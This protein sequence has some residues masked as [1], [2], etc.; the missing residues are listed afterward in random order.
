MPVEFVIS[1][2]IAAF[3]A[4]AAVYMVALGLRER[5][6]RLAA[7]GGGFFLVLLA[8]WIAVVLLLPEWRPVLIIVLLSGAGFLLVLFFAPILNR[9]SEVPSPTERVDERGVMFARSRYRP[10]DGR[11]EVF[12]GER[13]ELK[14]TDDAIRGMSNIGEP[15]GAAYDPLNAAVM[16]AQFDWIERIRETVDGPVAAEPIAISAEDAAA[17]LKG[18]ALQLGAVAVGT[19]AVAPGHVYSRNGRGSGEWGAEID[20]ARHPFALVFAVEM[21]EE[22]IA[23]APLAPVVVESSR[24]YVEAAK[25]ALVIAEYIRLLGY[26]ARAHIDGNY[27]LVLP[28][29]AADAGL[30]EVGRL[31][32]LLTPKY[33]PRVRLG[34]VSTSLPLPQD[35]PV[36]FGVEDFCNSCLKCA[37]NCPS[38]ALPK[39]GKEELRGTL[40]WRMEPEKC[41]R[42]WRRVGTDCGL[43]IAVCP[44]GHP[45]GLMHSF[46]RAACRRSAVSRRFFSWADDLFYGRSP[47]STRYP[48]WMLAGVDGEI[49]RRLKLR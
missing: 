44:Y 11:Y 3:L 23:A 29:L 25:I 39:G 24:K 16:F 6:P 47:R 9:S 48:P 33:G 10:G 45:Q 32:L 18:M 43:C 34:A 49:R 5:R 20:P 30:G 21:E 27:R 17:R 8:A 22:M 7:V 2:A 46:V 35:E 26:P 12:Y 36:A 37:R 42:Y 31:T 41:Y 28:Q 14:E 38:G 4:V 15:G 13:P 40:Y 1:S 19:T